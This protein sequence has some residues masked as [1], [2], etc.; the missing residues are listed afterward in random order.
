[1]PLLTAFVPAAMSAD[2]SQRKLKGKIPN[3]TVGAL[4]GLAGGDPT[5]DP[6]AGFSLDKWCSTHGDSAPQ[7][8]WHHLEPFLLVTAGSGERTATGV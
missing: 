5:L 8:T 2:Q 4:Q 3:S 1:M 7:E 6:R